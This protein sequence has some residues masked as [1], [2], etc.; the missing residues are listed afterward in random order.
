MCYITLLWLSA[1]GEVGAREREKRKRFLFD[2][3]PTLR[4]SNMPGKQGM[5]AEVL[6]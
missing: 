1:T 4:I 5:P 2:S 6:E 3:A